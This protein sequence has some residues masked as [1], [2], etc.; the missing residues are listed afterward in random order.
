[1]HEYGIYAPDR[2]AWMLTRVS[3]FP[4]PVDPPEGRQ[5]PGGFQ[6]ARASATVR[7]MDTK[8]R[9]RLTIEGGEPLDALVSVP[10]VGTDGHVFVD[11]ELESGTTWQL[12]VDPA[13]GAYL[14][15]AIAHESGVRFG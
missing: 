4:S 12:E 3:R 7:L 13:V 10:G 9:A 6:R 2:W 11:I 1:V 14:S 15:A 8:L 5:P